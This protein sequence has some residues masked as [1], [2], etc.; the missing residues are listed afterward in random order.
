MAFDREAAKQAGYSDEEI[1]AYL[2][3]QAAAPPPPAATTGTPEEPP[4]P[5][6]IVGTI[7]PT[8]ASI[9]TTAGLAAAPYVL[10]T[11]GAL[12]AGYGGSK[13]YGAW[14]AGTDAAQALAQSQAAQA[15]ADRAAAQGLQQRFEQRMAQQA[16]S[17]VRAPGP[18]SPAPTYNVPTSNVPQMRAP[19]P[20]TVSPVAPAMPTPTAGPA[21]LTTAAQP[22]IMQRGMDI[23][24]QMRQVA[25]SRVVPAAAQFARG[26]AAPAMALYSGELNPN[27]QAELERRRRMAPTITR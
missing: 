20:T 26:S 5:T 6:T 12:A 10:P 1:D 17:A 15:A 27:E 3:N 4:A 25:A 8:A 18:V 23:A 21:P 14:K 24:N 16:G 9:A 19:I 7:E 13:I 2:Q 22:G 11:A